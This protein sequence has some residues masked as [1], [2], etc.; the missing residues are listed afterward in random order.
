MRHKRKGRRRVLTRKL[1]ELMVK[2]RNDEILA[3]LD[4][5]R[6]HLNMENDKE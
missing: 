4:E 2:D 3:N 1:E 5:T 6:I